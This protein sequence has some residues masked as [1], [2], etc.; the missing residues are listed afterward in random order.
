MVRHTLK[1]L[2]QM[3]LDFQSV[4]DHFTTMRSKELQSFI[5]R[6]GVADVT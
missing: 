3:P 5:I 2:P 4:S 6:R 1:L